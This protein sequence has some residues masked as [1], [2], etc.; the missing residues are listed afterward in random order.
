LIVFFSDIALIFE[1]RLNLKV[2]N[3]FPALQFPKLLDLRTC[4][5]D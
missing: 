5:C 2:S 4:D 1:F 3:E